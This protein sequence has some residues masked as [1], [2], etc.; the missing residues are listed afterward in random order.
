LKD[1]LE[2]QQKYAG[3]GR[4]GFHFLIFWGMVGICIFV[5]FSGF[6]V[7]FVVNAY[8]GSRRRNE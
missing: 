7:V 3:E 4:V 8:D 6:S 1:Y 5:S 2:Y